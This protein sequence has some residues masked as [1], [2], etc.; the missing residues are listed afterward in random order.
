MMK[1]GG[2]IA[3]VGSAL[4]LTLATDIC[5]CA[6]W[7]ALGIPRRFDRAAQLKGQLSAQQN[8]PQNQQCAG[9]HHK[10]RDHHASDSANTK[11]QRSWL[12]IDAER[13]EE[14][15]NKKRAH[16]RMYLRSGQTGHFKH[17]GHQRNYRHVFSKVRMCTNR[18]AEGGVPTVS[19]TNPISSA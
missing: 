14:S 11:L 15:P 16:Q 12:G 1:N 8:L 9:D 6:E 13:M 5:N 18:A 3:G 17:G 4:Q 7:R 2:Q 19:K 10:N